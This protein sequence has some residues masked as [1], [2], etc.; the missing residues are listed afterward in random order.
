MHSSSTKS[1]SD[2]AEV[3]YDHVFNYMPA[4]LLHIN[5]S[6]IR[7]VHRDELHRIFNPEQTTP[8][9]IA[10]FMS[11]SPNRPR[12]QSIRDLV[13]QK[14]QYAVFSH[15]WLAAGEPTFQMVAEHGVVGNTPELEKLK[16]F[17]AVAEVL[18]CKLAWF[19]ACCIDKMSSA[20]LDEAI[21]SMFK[22]YRYS[23][24]C[25][26]HLAQTDHAGVGI[27]DD[28]W[29]RRGWTLQELLAPTRIKFYSA[30]W[31]PLSDYPN[32]KDNQVLMEHISK[33]TGIDHQNLRYFSPGLFN[34][35]EKMLWASL[36]KTTRT[37]DVAYSLL[38][39]FNISVPIAYGEGK[40]AFRRLMEAIA[41]E[42]R[43]WQIFAWAGPH[44]PYAT[45]FPE[46]PAGYRALTEKTATLL[47]MPRLVHRPWD[48]GYPFYTMTKKGLELGVLMVE[49][50]LHTHRDPIEDTTYERLT[51]GPGS[52]SKRYFEDTQVACDTR[53]L[54]FSQWAVGVINYHTDGTD[55]R[56][57]MAELEPGKEYVCFLFGTGIYSPHRKWEKVETKEVL[58][59][60]TK[61]VARRR[62]T[63][64]WL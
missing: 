58:T 33:I 59:I 54:H 51:F 11:K 20:E 43:E 25:I 56:G 3:F 26:V 39:I 7:L 27:E 42:C 37:E 17:C 38:G 30:N 63:I 41:E 16:N 28:P 12:A 24:V 31:L 45:S 61:E 48:L 35:R 21:R 8:A 53:F 18:G 13:S 47:V 2:V 32:D 14:L 52:G 19:D 6:D 50:M 40:R 64:V 23:A 22:W 4:R 9:E 34:V 62:M 44:S 10:S 49:M 57:G 1:N 29:F 60:R 46:S 5:K 36:R 55:E 15:R